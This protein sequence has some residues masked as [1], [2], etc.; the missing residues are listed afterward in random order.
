P[1][2]EQRVAAALRTALPDAHVSVSHEVAS[3]SREYERTSTT[4]IDAY[5]SP[6][7]ARYLGR[8]TAAAAEAGLPEPE[9][10]RSSGGLMSAAAAGS[11][12]PTP[13]AH[14]AWGRARQAPAP[15]RPATATAGPSPPSR[16]RTCCSAISARAPRWRAA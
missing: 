3:V 12:G 4:V 8:L 5:L 14:C 2:H 10:M 15:D 7:L 6:L 16:T 1:E 11:D 9:I 13:A